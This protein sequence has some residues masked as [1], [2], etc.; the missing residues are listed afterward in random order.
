MS[1]KYNSV[2]IQLSQT[3]ADVP[4][5]L[6]NKM[7]TGIVNPY[8]DHKFNCRDMKKSII[9]TKQLFWWKILHNFNKVHRNASS[10]ALRKFTPSHSQSNPVTLS[11][12]IL[13]TF[14]SFQGD[15]AFLLFHPLLEQADFF[16]WLEAK[17]IRCGGGH[18]GTSCYLSMLLNILFIFP[19]APCW[20]CRIMFCK[21]CIPPL[22]IIF[23][24]WRNLL[25]LDW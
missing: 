1:I 17:S 21:P 20:N 18:R 15:Y 14:S 7:T 13:W 12:W 10:F 16:L 5:T 24:E 6:K 22:K 19:E 8:R 3:P 25:L 9:Y 2:H 4:H 23:K 11:F